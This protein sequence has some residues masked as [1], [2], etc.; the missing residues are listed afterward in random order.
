MLVRVR[1][2]LKRREKREVKHRVIPA[3]RVTAPKEEN[4]SLNSFYNEGR[5]WDTE[6]CESIGAAI[7]LQVRGFVFSFLS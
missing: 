4:A 2:G 5:L 7:F 6:I 1:S 3:A